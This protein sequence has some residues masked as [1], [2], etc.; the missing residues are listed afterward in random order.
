MKNFLKR[1]NIEISVRRY[2]I[3]AMGHM[4]LG[5]F[6]SLLIG[7]ILN[8]LGS[9]LGLTFLTETLWPISRDMTGAAIGV[10]VA[11]ALKAPPLVLFSSVVTGAAG[12]AMGG[13]AGSFIAVL[14]ATEC[15]KIVSKETKVDIL[16]TPGVTVFVGVFVGSTVGPYIAEMM[17]ALGGF[18]MYATTLQPFLMGIILSVVM[19]MVLTLP[20][21]SAALAMMLS[22]GGLAGGAA[23][24]GCCAQMVGFAVMSYKENGWGGLV[25]QGLGTSMLQVPNIIRNWK[26]WI[27]PTLASVITGPLATLVFKMQNTPIGSGMG[28]SGFV[29][30]F[31]TYQAMSEAGVS[32]ATIFLYIGILHIL[33]PAALTLFFAKILRKMGWIKGN[34]LKLDLG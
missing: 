31:G 4:A 1:K 3:D 6:S 26:I 24:A 5:L 29:G 25:A 7:T 10:A 2:L 27:P 28:T 16:V 15:G 34:D 11:Y 14:I 33:L 20:I 9:K 22:L 12:N 32:P 21:S 18:I 30:Q 23:T 8:T 13:P 19:G 17:K